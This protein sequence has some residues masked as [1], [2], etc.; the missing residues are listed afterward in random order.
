MWCGDARQACSPEKISS[1][2]ALGPSSKIDLI[3][4]EIAPA[5]GKGDNNEAGG[6]SNEEGCTAGDNADVVSTKPT[7]HLDPDELRQSG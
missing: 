2:T 7:P 4:D 1:V 6:V 3:F 5:Q